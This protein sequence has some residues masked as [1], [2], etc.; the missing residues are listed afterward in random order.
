MRN[1][2]IVILLFFSANPPKADE[3]NY[4]NAKSYGSFIYFSS[5]P[6][7]LIFDGN[8]RENDSFEF[9][10]ATRNHDI[11]T[12][13][14]NSPGGSVSEGLTIAGMIFD[15]KLTTYIPSGSIC[16]SACAFMFFAGDT[17][18]SAGKLG[19]HQFYSE[20][21]S[22]SDSGISEAA[23]QYTVAEIIGFLNEFET[24]P[25]VF[26][27]MFSEQEMYFFTK[28]EMQLLNRTRD[29]TSLYENRTDTEAFLFEVRQH[30]KNEAKK[31]RNEENNKLEANQPALTPEVDNRPITEPKVAGRA[32]TKLIQ[33]EFN[34]IGC[35]LGKV[36]GIVG[37]KSRLALQKFNK[38][39]NS[40]FPETEF[41]NPKLLK[42]LKTKAPGFCP[43]SKDTQTKKVE[44]GD[45]QIWSGYEHCY[46][47]AGKA[48]TK[49]KL[50]I[51]AHN[52]VL[53]TITKPMASIK[54]FVELEL[55]DDGFYRGVT[56]WSFGQ[57][58]TYHTW[59]ID[60]HNG[61]ITGK[62]HRD[63][64]SRAILAPV[65]V[66]GNCDFRYKREN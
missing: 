30:L 39:N 56:P 19:V 22:T 10:K 2:F 16:A 58:K 38:K 20:K 18:Y 1:L 8:I 55:E 48:P 54:H 41:S 31:N 46:M 3:N 23:S 5:L 45:T 14:L 36:D 62:A 9:R 33:N 52:R 26:E 44:V 59:S 11:K 60:F 50:K 6:N 28:Q 57:G 17:R 61:V 53:V 51:L 15:K 63:L 13:V 65:L 7:A 43:K 29:E 40:K 49:V 32:L 21:S 27:R 4:F 12:I 64:V 42:I 37:R 66:S 24:P 35:N 25:F 47:L 34:R